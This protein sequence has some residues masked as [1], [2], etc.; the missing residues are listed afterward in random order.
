MP[1]S[2]DTYLNLLASFAYLGGRQDFIDG[3]FGAHRSGRANVM[4]DSGAFTKLNAKENRDWL[5]LDSYC[6]FAGQWGDSCEK[7]VMLDVIGNE[8]ETKKNYEIMVDRGLAPMFVLTM[9]DNDWAY[10]NHTM[11]VNE[12]CCVAGGTMTKGDWLIK[13]FQDA[14]KHTEKAI[15]IHALGY[16]TFPNIIRAPIVSGDSSTWVQGA[17]RY[18]QLPYFDR[19]GLHNVTYWDYWRGKKKIEPNLKEV[20]NR[21]EVTVPQFMD[22]KY[23]TGNLSIGTLLSMY[24]FI[25]YQ[26]YVYKFGKRLFL[27]VNDARNLQKILWVDENHDTVTYPKYRKEFGK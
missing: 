27:A 25:K 17:Q 23:H 18:G 19:K 2:N 9:F 11:K 6:D 12:N 15:K 22:R 24:A 26:R 21:L 13:R 20:L 3:F 1:R 5:N 16:V 8:P 10:L 4:I 7:Y 14:R